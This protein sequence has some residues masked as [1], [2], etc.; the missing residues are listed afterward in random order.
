ML[1]AVA[2]GAAAGVLAF[3]VCCFAVVGFVADVFCAGTVFL[4]CGL[5]AAF[6][7]GPIATPIIHMM[8][9]KVTIPMAIHFVLP[10]FLAKFG[11]RGKGTPGRGVGGPGARGGDGSCGLSCPCEGLAYVVEST[12]GWS[13]RCLPIPKLS[14][15]LSII[16]AYLIIAQTLRPLIVLAFVVGIWHV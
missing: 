9:R 8:A 1:G 16:H 15:P 10:L 2:T 11:F 4:A 13:T 12:G 5:L 7:L 3:S 14:S 6:F